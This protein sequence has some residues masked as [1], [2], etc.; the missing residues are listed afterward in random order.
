M[1]KQKRIRSV[2]T[3]ASRRRKLE[4]VQIEYGENATIIDTTSKGEMPWVK[5]SPFYPVGNIPIPFSD[6]QTAQSVEGIWQGLKVFE[7]EDIDPKRFE[8]KTMKGLK[9]T[10]RKYGKCLGHRDGINGQKLLGYIEARKQI[11]VP[12]YNWVLANRLSNLIEEL[13]ELAM[14]QTV[15]LLDYETNSNIEDIAK[16]LSHATLIAG[17]VNSF[18]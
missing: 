11:Y 8:I 9:R 18:G 1:L 4:N 6:P 17:A 7:S 3:I 10:L 2:I 5:F 14:N 12:A 13:V 16:P 15:V